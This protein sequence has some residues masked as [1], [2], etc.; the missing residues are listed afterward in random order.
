M[1]VSFNKTKILLFAVILCG[2]LA[3]G[4]VA[5]PN[6]LKD[7]VVREAK[8]AGYVEYEPMEAYKMANTICT[9]C[10]TNERIKMYCPRCGPPF[11]A[12]VPHMQAFI[13]NYKVTKP[14]L[15]ITN[16]TEAQAVAIVQVWNA[17][18]GNWESD[19]REQDIL[20]LI[21][22]YRQLAALYKTPVAER[23]IES[24]LAGREDL[25]IGHMSAL[26]EMQK[27]LGKPQ[28]APV[29]PPAAPMDHSGHEHGNDEH[30]HDQHSG[31]QH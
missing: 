18:V 7:Y 6:P 25:K 2:A 1:N 30:A 20:K 4:A 10:H 5:L 13:D 3:A 26:A 11:V 23:R 22:G 9:Q 8:A 15:E 28:P 29:E 14:D 21:G 12:V 31:P 16:I 19:F 27:N 24:A 17:L